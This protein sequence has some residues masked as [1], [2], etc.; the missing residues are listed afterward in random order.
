M[1]IA[2]DGWQGIRFG[3]PDNDGSGAGD[4]DVKSL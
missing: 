4:V 2:V 3:F 1:S